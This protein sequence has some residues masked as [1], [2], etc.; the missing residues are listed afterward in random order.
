MFIEGV[1]LYYKV[2]KSARLLL[3]EEA[4]LLLLDVLDDEGP[5]KVT[6]ADTNR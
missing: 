1:V 4:A 5:E 2:K 3:N 6:P